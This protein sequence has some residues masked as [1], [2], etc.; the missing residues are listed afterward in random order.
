MPTGL[1]HCHIIINPGHSCL[2]QGGETDGACFVTY[3]GALYLVTG[4]ALWKRPSLKAECQ[5]MSYP[6][7]PS[8]IDGQDVTGDERGLV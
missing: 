1:L 3:C 5:R 6:G 8:T 2:K 4:A 7:Q